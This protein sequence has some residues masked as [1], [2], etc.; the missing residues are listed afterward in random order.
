MIR[1]EECESEF[2]SITIFKRTDTGGLLYDQ[3]GCCQSETDGSGVSLAS[4]VHAIYGLIEQT[5]A[6]NILMIGCGG[7]TLGTMLFRAGYRVTIVDINPTSFALARR[8]FDLPSEI[9]CQV[10]DGSDYLLSETTVYDVIVLDA[11]HGDRIPAHLQSLIF[12][13]RARSRLHGHGCLLAN[14]HIA[15]DRDTAADRLARCM[16]K[17]WSDVRLLDAPG[18]D[19]RNAIVVAGKVRKFVP[20]KLSIEPSG[21]AAAIG[22]ELD[23]MHF[24][25]WQEHG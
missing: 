22:L 6:H 3:N 20:P 19:N 2:G 21:F 15:D 5:K 16:A 13:E 17:I 14:V 10:A 8:H 7:G 12:F 11:F 23:T 9:A 24:R 25:S 1:L 4:Y 18:Y